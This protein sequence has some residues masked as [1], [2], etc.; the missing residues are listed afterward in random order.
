MITNTNGMRSL[1]SKRRD[2]EIYA[3]LNEVVVLGGKKLYGEFYIIEVC[4]GTFDDL[5]STRC[6][7][8]LR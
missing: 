7:Y 5:I 1:R 6:L 8:S 2:T 3:E 4:G